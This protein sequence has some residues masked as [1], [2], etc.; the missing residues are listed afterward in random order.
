MSLIRVALTIVQ[1][2]FNHKACTPPHPTPAKGRYHTEEAYILQIAP[3]VFKVRSIIHPPN[4]I[5]L[6]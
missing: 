4:I 6:S 5:A 2:I 1:A 3:A